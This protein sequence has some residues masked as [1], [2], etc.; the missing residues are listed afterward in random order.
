MDQAADNPKATPRCG[1]LSAR[2]S[3]LRI[4]AAEVPLR[5]ARHGGIA[6][7]CGPARLLSSQRRVPRSAVRPA[8]S[9]LE[10]T[11]AVGILGI[12]LVIV[13]AVFPVALSQHRETTARQQATELLSKAESMLRS[14]INEDELW[15][16]DDLPT[17][18]D[19]YWCLLPST[20]LSYLASAWDSML[21]SVP[22]TYNSLYATAYANA[23]NGATE[24]DVVLGQATPLTL[25][26]L[27]TLSDRV[28]PGSAM[29][30]FTDA[31]FRQEA[32]RFAWYGFYR[33]LGNG[34]TEYAVA[35]CRQQREQ[36]FAQQYL[37]DNDAGWTGLT[38]A[39]K[40]PYSTPIRAS[41]ALSELRRLPVPWRV[42][43]AR[44]VLSTRRLFNGPSWDMLG[45]GIPLGVLAPRGSK[46]MIHGATHVWPPVGGLPWER[47]P[48]G[49]ILTVA[50]VD[51]ANPSVIETVEDLSDLPIFAGS[52]RRLTFD[53]WIFPPPV[54]GTEFESESPLIDWTPLL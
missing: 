40:N 11:I 53:V 51:D 42:S 36:L 44:D 24:T 17:G 54:T 46:I 27:D 31:E 13:A 50:E 32:L 22:P 7:T 15:V 16:D 4:G 28:A 1:S 35:V 3:R 39:A 10:T 19:A 6:C 34:S 37:G 33:R 38:D 47:V 26:G 21:V 14:R 48:A 41:D 2:P 12:G 29:S 43:V 49:R 20:S 45:A 25:F 8:F 5:C 9:L 52:S 18:E 23:I 30:P